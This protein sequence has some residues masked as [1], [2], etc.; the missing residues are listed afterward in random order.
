MRPSETLLSGLIERHPALPMFVLAEVIGAALLAP[1]AAG[2][3]PPDSAVLVLAAF[4][5]SL[6]GVIL[7]GLTSGSG[8]LRALFGRLL[9]WRASIGW[10]LLALFGVAAFYLGG[11]ALASVFTGSAFSLDHVGPLYLVIP[12]LIFTIGTHGGLG[13]ELG[14]RGF[15]LPRLQARH[16]ALVS[17]I[18]VGMLWGLWHAPLF[19]IE[20]MPFY[21]EI[22]QAYGVVPSVLGLAFFLT[23][24][25]SILLSWMYN[26]TRGS[27]LLVCVFHGAEAWKEFFMDPDTLVSSEIGFSAV[28]SAVAIVV[29][30]VYGA[31]HLSRTKERIRF[32]GA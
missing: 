25:W 14:W 9:V 31:E 12:L 32:E 13:E 3:V 22:G 8:G 28:L 6:A 19:L 17:S 21:Y 15:L 26:N 4:S 2:V 16:N 27:L 29:V 30:L 18:I 23:V 20:G 24:P 10:W 11:M 5:A 7:T 1:I